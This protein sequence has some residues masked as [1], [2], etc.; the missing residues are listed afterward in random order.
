[1]N[2]ATIV[3]V[4]L[5]NLWPLLPFRIVR[6]D[7][8]GVRW[9]KWGAVAEIIRPG[10]VWCWYVVHQ[11]ERMSNGEAV[12]DLPTQS[13]V[14]AD[15]YA[16]CL[17]GIVNW[18]VVDP[19]KAYCNVDNLEASLRGVALRHLSKNIRKRKY[20]ET[21][22]NMDALEASLRRTL[23]TRCKH[24]GVE[25]TDVGLSDFVHATQQVRLFQDAGREGI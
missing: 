2:P 19:V 13:V 23:E 5:S 3:E 21:V 18:R 1:M 7:E 11:F 12:L 17:S 6:S 8:W 24:W 4:L 10:F 25:I 9:R 15:E 22:K 14:T 16:V 20:T